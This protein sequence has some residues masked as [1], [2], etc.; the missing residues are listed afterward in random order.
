MHERIS[1]FCVYTMTAHVQH[2]H[3]VQGAWSC[4][5][6]RGQRSACY[7]ILPASMDMPL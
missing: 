4:S 7:A 2:A 1:S 5:D 3:K 6:T